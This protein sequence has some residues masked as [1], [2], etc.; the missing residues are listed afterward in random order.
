[1]LNFVELDCLHAHSAINQAERDMVVNHISGTTVDTYCF[2]WIVSSYSGVVR[3]G[4]HTLHVTYPHP[5]MAVGSD[6]ELWAVD[7]LQTLGMTGDGVGGRFDGDGRQRQNAR[8][9]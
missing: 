7:Q 8:C 5:I 3:S 1:M 9:R 2:L 4:V 6:D